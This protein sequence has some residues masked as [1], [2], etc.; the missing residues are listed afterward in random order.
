MVTSEPGGR[1]A[2]YAIYWAP[3][4]DSA[5]AQTGAQWLGR[6]A[7]T[8][9][10][11]TRPTVAGF[12]DAALAALT[13]EPRRY[14][15]HATLKPPFSLAAAT[16]V[17]ALEAALSEFATV[18]TPVVLPAIRVSRIGNFVALVPT[19]PT[20][21]VTALANACVAQF[22]RYRAPASEDEFTRRNGAGLTPPQQANLRRW[23]YPYVMDEFRFHVT[24]T[25]PLEPPLGDRLVPILS[26]LFAEVTASP[27]SIDEIA[28]FVESGRGQPFRLRRRFTLD[29]R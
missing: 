16:T 23:G 2:R 20:P 25:G 9:R 3:P 12:D 24:L 28:L 8:D 26:K 18:T 6:D 15:L 11:L 4:D 17:T 22:D 5:L 19:V 13:A 21:A 27:I 29:G 14:G 1:D 7:V 10:R